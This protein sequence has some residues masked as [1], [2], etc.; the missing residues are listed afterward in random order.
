MNF[1][2]NCWKTQSKIH[3]KNDNFAYE[4]HW[5]VG[6]WTN[7]ILNLKVL[8][9]ELQFHA[10]AQKFNWQLPKCLMI[11]YMFLNDSDIYICA[12]LYKETIH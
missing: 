3:E 10:Q 5:E 7:G 6:Y 4:I 11:F 2:Y 12:I 8:K 9:L 1:F